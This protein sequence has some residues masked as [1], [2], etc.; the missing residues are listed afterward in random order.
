MCARDFL[1]M[2]RKQMMHRLCNSH[3][4][5]PS[6]LDNMEYKGVSLGLPRWVEKLTWKKFKK[7]FC[8]DPQTGVLRGWNVRI[9]QDG[10]DE[11]WTPMMKRG[12]RRTFGHYQVV[13]PAGYKMPKPCGGGLLIHYGLGGNR[14]FGLL[15]RL[16]DPIVAVNPD[17]ADLLLG[18]SYLDLGFVRF[19]T[20]SFFTL[21][22][23]IE[24]THEASPPRKPA[25]PTL[26]R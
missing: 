22:R 2:S 4:I 21:E 9:V 6:A 16:R 20:P 8:R 15:P 5:E 14:R 19:G 12:E 7:V 25:P 11:P 3:P 26:S 18:W 23:D 1:G 10:L 24:L 13:D 17:S